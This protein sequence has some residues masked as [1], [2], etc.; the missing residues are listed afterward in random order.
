MP[1]KAGLL[2]ENIILIGDA[3]ALC[4]P[5]HGGGIDMACI[6]GHIAAE[7]IASNRVYQY[8]ARLWNI[9]GKKLTM[10]MRLLKLWHFGGYS[11]VPLA[12]R[13]PGLLRGVFF[14]K[15]PYPQT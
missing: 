4:S 8:P 13:H 3:A 9:V 12:F 10:E 11:F 15:R 5:L 2:W 7:L 1:I 6:S 14:N